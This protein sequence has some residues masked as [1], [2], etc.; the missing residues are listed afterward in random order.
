M[1]LTVSEKDPFLRSGLSSTRDRKEN[2]EADTGSPVDRSSSRFLLM[3]S[4]LLTN[5]ETSRAE[6]ARPFDLVEELRKI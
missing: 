4:S 6:D 1:S 2:I 5:G 3:L